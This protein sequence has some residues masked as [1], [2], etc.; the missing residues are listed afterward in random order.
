[1][2]NLNR[3]IALVNNQKKTRARLIGVH[4]PFKTLKPYYASG[5]SRQLDRKGCAGI[6]T[7]TCDGN[8]LYIETINFRSLEQGI[9]YR[10]LHLVPR[11]IF[12]KMRDVNLVNPFGT[13]SSD[14]TYFRLKHS[15][16]TGQPGEKT[17]LVEF[18]SMTQFGKPWY[19]KIHPRRIVHVIADSEDWELQTLWVQ[20]GESI[21]RSQLDRSRHLLPMG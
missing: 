16:F 20:P 1:M 21:T 2:A 11:A 18:H 14:D 3:P 17:A 19:L 7:I 6:L 12:K 8:H 4:D 10:N 9:D 13:S 5:G 15:G